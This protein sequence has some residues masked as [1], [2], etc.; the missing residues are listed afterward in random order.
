MN[1]GE[2][3]L[4]AAKAGLLASVQEHSPQKANAEGKEKRASRNPDGRPAADFKVVMTTTDSKAK[5]QR[6]AT[7]YEAAVGHAL[8]LLSMDETAE[9][10]IQ[11]RVN[12][13]T[14][15]MQ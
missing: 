8:W 9:I 13:V 7:S 12:D 1:Q 5:V 15:R 3:N 2:K 11:D 14:W 10:E 4:E 6:V